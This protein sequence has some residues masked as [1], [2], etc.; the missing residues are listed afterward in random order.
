MLNAAN[1]V[2]VEMFLKGLIKY[3]DIPYYIEETL[4]SFAVEGIVCPESII[5]CDARVR[6]FVRE[7]VKRC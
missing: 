1:E 7:L 5:D 3:L 2:L 4:G 6:R